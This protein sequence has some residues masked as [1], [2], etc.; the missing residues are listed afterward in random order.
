MLQIMTDNKEKLL[1]DLLDKLT[2]QNTLLKEMRDLL[3]N[4]DNDMLR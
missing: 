2:E 3:K 4:I 1:L